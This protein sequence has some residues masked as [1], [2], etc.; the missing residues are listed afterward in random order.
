MNNVECFIFNE[1]QMTNSLFLPPFISTK[2][3]S[4]I[5]NLSNANLKK[6]RKNHEYC[7]FEEK[8]VDKE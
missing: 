3:K 6:Q 7:F 5:P 2:P 8:L 1:L 4:T